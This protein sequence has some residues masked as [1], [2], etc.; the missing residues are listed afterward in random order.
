MIHSNEKLDDLCVEMRD[1][2]S[3]VYT[4]SDRI[5]ELEAIVRGLDAGNAAGSYLASRVDEALANPAQKPRRVIVALA[6]EMTTAGISDRSLVT[7]VT[8]ALA[9]WDPRGVAFG[10]SDSEIPFAFARYLAEAVDGPNEYGSSVTRRVHNML[11]TQ[12]IRPGTVAR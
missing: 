4:L 6:A 2:R 11:K 3:L 8:R 1:L 12:H 7:F 10:R 9:E 5:I